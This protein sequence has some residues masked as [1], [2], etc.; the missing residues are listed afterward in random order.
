MDSNTAQV[1]FEAVYSGLRSG[2]SD[3]KGILSSF[4]GGMKAELHDMSE[5]AKV[6]SKSYEG[7]M[8][9]LGNVV[10]NKFKGLNST[11]EGVKKAWLQLGVA[12]EAAHFMKESVD[13]AVKF[14]VESMKLSRTLNITTNAASGLAIA[15]GDVHGTSEEYLAAVK[16]LDRNLKNHEATI[17]GMGLATRDA[18]G[19]LRN[20]NDLTL[21][22]MTLLRGYKEGTDRNIAAQAIF[23]KGVNVSNEMLALSAE[24]MQEGTEKAD[25]LNLTLGV[26]GKEAT[27][28]YRAAM[29]DF[30]D[31]LLG[32][33]V[34]LGNALMPV[35]TDFAS[36]CADIGPTAILALRIAINI[37]VGL[38]RG[39]ALA[40]KVVWEVVTLAFKNMTESASLFGEI[41]S[42]VM[43]GDFAGAADA[44]KRLLANFATNAEE[45]FGRIGDAAYDAG[46]KT[47]DSF[48]GLFDKQGTSG[49]QDGGGKG[50][51]DPD[52]D[53]K[54]AK[55][56]QAA[57]RAAAA[58]AKRAAQEARQL[59]LDEF[60]NKMEIYKGEEAAA[61]GHW[62]TILEIQKEELKE[63]IKLYGEDS[64]E[65]QAARNR[66]L[67]TERAAADEHAKIE[68]LKTQATR[69]ASL[70]RID[71]EEQSAQAE[72]ALGTL[73]QQELLAKQ[74]EFENQRYQIRLEA[75][76]AQAALAADE[77]VKQQ[78]LY[79]Q[80]EVMEQQH[81]LA[82]QKI[83]EQSALIST[84]A[85]RNIWSSLSNSFGAA[86]QGMLTKQ[87][88]FK[89]AAASIWQALYGTFVQE[90]IVKP[91]Q[92]WVMRMA[93]EIVMHKA[94]AL[95]KSLL[96]KA[97]AASNITKSAAMAG[98]AGTASMAAA[99][100][101]LDMTAPAFGAAMSAA[102]LAFMPG[103]AASGGYDIPAGTN[104]IVQAHQKEMILPAAQADVIRS[105]ADGGSGG[106]GPTLHVHV[107][108][109]DSHD[110][111]RFLMDNRRALADSIKS[112]LRDGM[113]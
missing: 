12:L 99:P 109:M 44:G 108:A 79:N 68:E 76:Q 34:T 55:A 107:N 37:L 75:A 86:L 64:R 35:L 47:V 56:A 39:L 111:R 9:Q 110:V 91:L 14:N 24:K 8:E 82:L 1:K 38:F 61:K 93:R 59:A 96:E 100:W 32:V 43:S 74:T 6:D 21:D 49:G 105:L 22:A 92:Q 60:Q 50:Y 33:K 17:Q 95:Q 3:A 16:G 11:F 25:A 46:S 4:V 57:A 13:E 15:I 80:I 77:P 41:F 63:T 62:D 94:N 48:T 10:Q 52:A 19:E 29:N 70:A 51:A 72:V 73:T 58:E 87:M 66:I 84:E 53:D 90:M 103:A 106:G 18:N 2:L 88:T 30:Q 78:E 27:E 26:Q 81:Q 83:R 113:R 7:T 89:Q 102:A 97:Q 31:T 45:S 23:G 98:A 40:V 5:Q 67:A 65:A 104:P 54:A 28:K 42:K 112:A 101:P 69:Q 85:N 20:Q 36:F 71:S